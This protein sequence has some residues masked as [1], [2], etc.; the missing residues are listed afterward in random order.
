[1]N[2]PNGGTSPRTLDDLR[3]EI[4]E[5]HE[6][7]V[8]FARTAL[9]HARRT[10]TPEQR[11][12]LVKRLAPVKTPAIRNALAQLGEAILTGQRKG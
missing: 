2:S 5:R 10:L 4:E 3:R 9:E 1:M 12:A 7:Y 11:E 8:K 6:K